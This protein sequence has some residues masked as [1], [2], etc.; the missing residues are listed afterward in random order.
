MKSYQ[1]YVFVAVAVS[2]LAL[3]VIMP[4]LTPLT[5]E[6][7]LADRHGGAIVS[8]GSIIMALTAAFWGR[9]SDA[10]GR[11][12]GILSGF[13]GLAVGY[14][15]FTGLV[16]FGLRGLIVG[17]TLFLALALARGLTG[18]A[19]PAVPVSAQALIA[20]NTTS[21]ERS[22]AMALMGLA[23]GVGMVVGPA[24]GGILAG[25]NLILPLYFTIGLATAGALWVGLRMENSPPMARS[26][27]RTRLSVRENGLWSW[28]LNAFCTF[29]AIFTIQMTAGYLVQDRLNVSG[30]SA[31]SILSIAF[32]VVG[33][34]LIFT[35]TMQMKFLKWSPLRLGVTGGPLLAIGILCLLS[36]SVPL[37]FYGAY[38]VMGVGAGMLITAVNSGASLAV[39]PEK[40]GQIGGLVGAAQGGAAIIAPF[41]STML[42]EMDPHLPF[43]I[44]LVAL[45]VALLSLLAARQPKAA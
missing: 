20:D 21:T 11:K 24:I 2:G 17:T 19:L 8:F 5:R 39:G 34:M 41:G 43:L 3:S 6:L 4:I 27:D 37:M 1:K 45:A 42:Y 12:L 10:R 25:V 32:C 16:I 38:G 15:L 9:L 33:V 36:A 13:I 18:A 26:K 35:Q 22:A 28:L 14:A 40:Q 7:G 30:S 23:Q 44:L 29:T 31:A